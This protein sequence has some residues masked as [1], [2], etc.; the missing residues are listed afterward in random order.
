[1]VFMSGGFEVL[2]NLFIVERQC[3]IKYKHS[4]RERAKKGSVK[5]TR[6]SVLENSHLMQRKGVGRDQWSSSTSVQICR[7]LW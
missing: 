7:P 1:M 2:C 4:K 5:K 3:Q 6:A